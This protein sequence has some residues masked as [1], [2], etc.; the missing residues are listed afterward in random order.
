MALAAY[1]ASH[2]CPSRN[3]TYFL[4]LSNIV[5]YQGKPVA[6]S[7]LLGYRGT[8]EAAMELFTVSAL[9]VET[10]HVP[11]LEN[12]LLRWSLSTMGL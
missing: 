4:S 11:V 2:R 10:E 5:R 12:S 7:F 1:R 6:A 8:L 3:R 9:G